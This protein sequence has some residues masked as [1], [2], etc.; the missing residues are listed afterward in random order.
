M[1]FECRMPNVWQIVRP[2][3]Q[4]NLPAL[5]APHIVAEGNALG[6]KEEIIIQP[7]RG[8]TNQ[9]FVSMPCNPF[10]ITVRSSSMNFRMQHVR[11]VVAGLLFLGCLAG[12]SAAPEPPAS[13]T[14]EFTEGR[15][16]YTGFR[17]VWLMQDKPDVSSRRGP[18]LTGGGGA[19]DMLVGRPF[20]GPDKEYRGLLRFENLDIPPDS[21]ILLAELNLDN[22]LPLD[23]PE[24]AV[25]GLLK[26]FTAPPREPREP[27]VLVDENETT[28]NSQYH[29]RT[30][31][32]APGA[33]KSGDSFTYDAGADHFAEPDGVATPV[34][35]A[36]VQFDV[37]RS[38]ASQLAHGKLYGWLLREISGA[39]ETYVNPTSRR[40]R[41]RVTYVPPPDA[42]PA[43][44]PPPERRLICFQL[45][46]PQALVEDLPRIE[47][48]PFQGAVFFGSADSGNEKW[49]VNNVFGPDRIEIDN[50][51]GFIEAGRT[52]RESGTRLT[53]NFLRVNLCAPGTLKRI[54][55]P[56]HWDNMPRSDDPVRM[57]WDDAFDTVIHN[58]EVA[59]R[60]ARQ[61]GMAGIFFDAEEY[62]GNIFSYD[63]QEDA[64]ELVKS[65]EDTQAQVRL[66]GGQVAE[67]INR[68]YPDMAVIMYFSVYRE[69]P[70]GNTNSLWN[71]YMDGF[72]EKMDPRMR[73]VAANSLAYAYVARSRFEERYHWDYVEAPKISRVPEKYLRQ[74]EVGLGLFCDYNG[75]DD[76]PE[77]F[78][79]S[80]QWQTRLENALAVADSYVWV[81]SI[82]PNWWTGKNLPPAY[83]DATFRALDL[84]RR[85]AALD[86]SSGD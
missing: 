64:Q 42:P 48:Q 31:W 55:E 28:W 74:V 22:G 77:L 59:A 54:G 81:Y 27:G 26:P 20:T 83:L 1:D 38:F 52:L 29:G 10:P 35:K 57:W 84:A 45:A 40:A 4:D 24:M 53:D 86:Y 72:I 69:L 2:R 19:E 78:S 50:Y 82:Q 44:L 71:D 60:V 33:G 14:V 25:F 62:R 47:K 43:R 6:K 61:A 79:S 67:A 8:C 46:E 21:E 23:R 36:R 39:G 65:F 63:K 49:I 16:G 32:G 9:T 7:C 68:H 73:I 17:C 80:A 13:V 34:M 70:K 15:R 58:M 30:R 5:K 37:T 51:A 3:C 85:R 11:T 66:R 75:W 18:W 76:D 56:Y 12:A 41:L